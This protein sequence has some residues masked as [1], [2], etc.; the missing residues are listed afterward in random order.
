MLTLTRHVGQSLYVKVG[1]VTVQVVITHV[2]AD[3]QVHLG[4]QAPAAVKV[5]RGELVE[6]TGADPVAI[7]EPETPALLAASGL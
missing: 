6:T 2:Q 4:V 3:K 7:S 5:P 1:G